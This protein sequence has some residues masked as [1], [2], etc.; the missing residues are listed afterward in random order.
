MIIE[1]LGRLAL[2]FQGRGNALSK[3]LADRKAKS[4]GVQRRAAAE[5]SLLWCHLS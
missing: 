5:V 2:M 3:Y 4:E 1:S